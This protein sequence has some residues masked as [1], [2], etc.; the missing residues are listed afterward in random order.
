M[1][2]ELDIEPWPEPPLD[3]ADWDVPHA[4]P[5]AA[6]IRPSAAEAS[7]GIPHINNVV[8]VA[9]LDRVAEL[10]ADGLGWTRS[11]MVERDLA[12]FVGRHEVDY[13]AET[14]PGDELLAWTWIERAGRTTADRRTVVVRTGGS[15]AEPALVCRGRTTWVHVRLSTRRPVRQDPGLVAALDPLHLDAR[16]DRDGSRA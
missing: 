10:H 14:W 13:V 7:R 9:W 6:R 8:Y 15:E 1:I 12:W 4:A 2:G 5:F 3:P 11:A 16:R